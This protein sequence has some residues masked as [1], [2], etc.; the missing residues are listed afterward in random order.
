[1]IKNFKWLLLVSLSFVACNNNDDDTAATAEVPVTPGSASFA[2][3]VAL[4][5]SFAAGYSDGA[6]FKKGQETSYPSVLAQ[7]FTQAG[8][9]AF[10]VP[11][12]GNDNLGGLL[13][14]GTPIAETR[15]YI[16]GFYPNGRPIIQN[17]PGVPVTDVTTHLTGTFNNLGVPGAKSFD[18]LSTTYGNGN[19]AGFGTGATSPYFSRFSSS[20]MASVIG[21][22]LVQKPTF[23][24]LWIGGN[25]VL[26]YALSGGDGTNPIT[27]TGT[28]E[29]A[30][31]N[32]VTQLSTDGRK[33]VVANLPFITTLP[34]FSVVSVKP[35]SP[36]AY[37][38]DG[39]ENNKV[40]VIS[41]GD[42]A[43]INAL[44]AQLLGPLKQVLTGLGAGDR[45]ELLS[46]TANNPVLIVD[47]TLTD[48]K[49][50]ITGA[51]TPALGAATAGFYGA[52]FGKVRQ[53][54]KDGASTD[55]ILLSTSTVIGSTAAG[56]PS[57]L[58]KYGIS[59]PLQDKHVLIPSE[60]SEMEAAV[61]AYNTIIKNAADAKGLAYVDAKSAM[62]QLSSTSGVSFGNF[63][64]TSS[65][66]TGGAFSL[67]GVHPT[68]RGYAY[69]ANLFI[70]AINTKYGS[71]LRKVDLAEYQ[72]LFP[73]MI[74]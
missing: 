57:P 7:Q 49:Q 8:G 43:T 68:P 1:M 24:S 19:P 41:A 45:I 38:V 5:D 29:T 9:G 50:Q 67:D 72:T 15:K 33:G 26:G 66:V 17:V 6:L 14:G 54:K 27:P 12:C 53:T 62:T 40:P 52:V 31:N 63:Q 64:M 48:Y 51:L 37:F 34:N 69:I 74:Q 65:Y 71:T 25:D 70:D 22:A 60:I 47:E 18:L 10:N 16:S 13:Y 44:N 3:Y 46:T 23:F 30:Y 58:N 11:F 4:G 20:A 59:Y 32:L 61:I 56:A 42:I 2:K 73:G 39:D 21:D 36:S 28:F 35:V 55:L